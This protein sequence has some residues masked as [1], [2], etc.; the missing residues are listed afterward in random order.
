MKWNWK[1]YGAM[2]LSL[3]IAF[4]AT[5]ALATDDASM[6]DVIQ[7]IR[8]TDQLLGMVRGTLSMIEGDIARARGK[9]G[10]PIKDLEEEK[11][12]GLEMIE[13]LTKERAR[14]QKIVNAWGAAFDAN[15]KL[16]AKLG[17]LN[18]TKNRL[19]GWKDSPW[20]VDGDIT[21]MKAEIKK[22]EKEI[23]ALR[24][25]AED[26]QREFENLMKKNIVKE[27]AT[28]QLRA[29][30]EAFKRELNKF[31]DP[32]YWEMRLDG[33]MVPSNRRLGS[34]FV[35][36]L[37]PWRPQSPELTPPIDMRFPATIPLRP[38]TQYP[39]TIPFPQI[40]PI[41]PNIYPY[42]YQGPPVIIPFQGQPAPGPI[43]LPF[44]PT[45][46]K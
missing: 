45:P 41:R 16:G 37:P 26:A 4:G 23:P 9:A 30:T 43:L 25:A 28:D 18:E 46:A 22:L 27:A 39:A 40:F 38:Q 21:R 29:G 36:Q 5:P 1:A 3:T 34:R 12:T 24:K 11:K 2:A 44:T 17:E 13:N 10:A 20:Y 33:K 42:I 35:G 6:P 8:E 19:P 31:P 15:L 14:L 7:A 32:D